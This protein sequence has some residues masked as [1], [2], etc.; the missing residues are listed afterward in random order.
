MKIANVCLCRAFGAD[1]GRKHS[2][3]VLASMVAKDKM[4]ELKMTFGHCGPA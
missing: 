2:R 4:N 1:G 3:V